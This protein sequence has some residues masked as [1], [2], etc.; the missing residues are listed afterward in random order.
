[1]CD[2][3]TSPAK[4]RDVNAHLIGRR[5]LLSQL[6]AV[7]AATT[8]TSVPGEAMAASDAYA[9]PGNAKLPKSDMTLD[10]ARTALV[11]IDPQIDF[12]S[13]TGRAWAAV[14]Q[15][16]TEQNLVPNLLRL[17]GAAKQAEI[18]VAI[19][20]HYYYPQDYRWKFHAPVETLQHDLHLFDRKDALNLEG[21]TGSGADFLPAFK[22]FIN[23]G[24]TIVCSPHKLYGP[25]ANDLVL[26]LGKQRV[27][28]I[29]LAGMLANLCVESH[30]RHFLEMGFEVAVVRDA[31]AAPKLPDGDGYLSALINFRYLA[32]ALWTTDETVHRLA[33][34]A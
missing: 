20:P 23:D 10:L 32:N 34:K 1:M 7:A 11:I 25:Q 30:L 24:K 14:G 17:F 31:V 13:P 29:V 5:S 6:A 2:D 18:A 28:Q 16:V 27:N 26:Q 19:S 33:R 8:A 15:S 4:V 3:N 22:P 12:M 9:D 21:F